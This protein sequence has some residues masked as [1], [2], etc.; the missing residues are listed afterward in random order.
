MAILVQLDCFCIIK[1]VQHAS[2]FFTRVTRALALW[3]AA[4]EVGDSFA[5]MSSGTTGW[6]YSSPAGVENHG[7][8]LPAHQLAFGHCYTR[9]QLLIS[10]RNRA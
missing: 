5:E 8:E 3:L 7:E 1:I 10:V 4:G 2:F 9:Q 6:T